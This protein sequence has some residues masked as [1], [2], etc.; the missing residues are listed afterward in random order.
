MGREGLSAFQTPSP[1][2]LLSSL[3]ITNKS[4]QKGDKWKKGGAGRRQENRSREA[5]AFFH[6]PGTK[7]L[8]HHWNCHPSTHGK[9]STYG[10]HTTMERAWHPTL[11]HKKMYLTSS[12]FFFF[13]DLAHCLW[14]LSRNTP[15]SF[16][17]RHLTNRGVTGPR[18]HTLSSPT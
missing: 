11:S 1:H 2:P 4:F 8:S 7:R 9:V 3:P 17:G 18:A 10:G 14:G 16:I 12:I 5:G 15:I 13:F 6:W